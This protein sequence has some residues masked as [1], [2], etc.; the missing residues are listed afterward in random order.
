MRQFF[1][2]HSRLNSATR[3]SVCASSVMIPSTPMS[4][5]FCIAVGS[6][7]VQT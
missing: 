2:F 4:I 5:K 3:R 7:I 1:H 6:S